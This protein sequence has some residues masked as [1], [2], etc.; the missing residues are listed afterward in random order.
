MI[1]VNMK[2]ISN[3]ILSQ[4][5]F[6]LFN[7]MAGKMLNLSENVDGQWQV[8]GDTFVVGCSFPNEIVFGEKS[9]SDNPDSKH[10]LYSTKYGIYE[11]HCGLDNLILSY[12][13][14]LKNSKKYTLKNTRPSGHD[15]YLFH[16]LKN[17]HGC[18]LPPDAL[19]VIRYHS[20]YPWHLQGCYD[21]LV[22]ADTDA[23]KLEWVRKFNSFDL[24]SKKDAVVVRSDVEDYYID[25]I[26]EFIPG[27]IE[28]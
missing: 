7:W 24:Y 19:D 9:F 25:L 14:I 12:G 27:L 16:V 8:V 20:F 17:H 5:T 21:H 11:P 6:F 15:E 28:W 23:T 2:T 3:Y 26:D 10:P 4:T 18:K 1:R 22:N 13:T